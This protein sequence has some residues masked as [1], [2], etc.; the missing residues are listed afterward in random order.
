MIEVEKYEEALKLYREEN[1]KRVDVCRQFGLD[2]HAFTYFLKTHHPELINRHSPKRLSGGNLHKKEE[3]ERKYRKAVR[4]AETSDLTY[5]EIAEKTGVTAI[6]LT[7]HIQRYHRDLMLRRQ[8]VSVSKREAANVK[9]RKREA[10]M[11]LTTEE[12]YRKAVAACLDENYITW[13]ISQ[14]AREYGLQAVNLLTH[15]RN[16]H[17]ELLE[18]R[19]KMREERGISDNRQRGARESTMRKYAPAIEL[20]RSSDKTIEQVA[21]ECRVGLA[22]L[23]THLLQYHRDVVEQRRER[24]ENAVGNQRIGALNGVGQ[25]S[26]PDEEVGEHYREAVE[27]YRTTDM[28]MKDIATKTGVS[29]PGLKYHLNRWHKALVLMRRMPVREVASAEGQV[30]G[31]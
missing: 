10:G 23:R 19:E 20:L 9:L 17:P 7:S 5:K 26:K 29:L 30:P 6:G 22:G 16:R 4:L 3:A 12:K 14:I 8:G 28:T 11:A 24:I 27:L 31:A 1:R 2:Y 25:I 18:Q 13:P 21:E 15:L